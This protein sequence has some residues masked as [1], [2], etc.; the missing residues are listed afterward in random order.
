MSTPEET[1]FTFSIESYISGLMRSPEETRVNVSRGRIMKLRHV[2]LGLTASL[3][4]A[5]NL[6]AALGWSLT[7]AQRRAYLYYYAPLLMHSAD[8]SATSQWGFDWL[9]NFDFD[10]DGI[11]KNNKA[12]WEQVD[13]LVANPTAAAYASWR[14]RPTM[15]T[16]A[17]EYMEGTS[18]SLTMLYHVYHAK[19]EGSIHDWERIEIRVDNV[20]GTP[21]MSETIRYVTITQHETHLSQLYG[22][23]DL[24]FMNTTGG[25]HAMIWQDDMQ[26]DLTG[27]H[28]NQLN[29]IEN[30][31]SQID[32]WNK[33][34][35]VNAEVDVTQTSGQQDVH[36]IFVPKGDAAAVTYW[37][38]QVLTQNT[39]SQLAAKASSRYDRWSKIK[40]IQYE[41]QDLADIMPTHADCASCGG[42][43]CV[44]ENGWGTYSNHWG[45]E[46]IDIKLSERINS[47][48]G[49]QLV[50]ASSSCGGT[51]V[52]FHR[53]SLDIEDPSDGAQGYPHKHWF[54]GAYL[55]NG[56]GESGPA[57]DGT[58]FY[59][60]VTG[61]PK[62]RQCTGGL[63]Q[64]W[65]Q[66]DYFAHSGP[67]GS[68]SNGKWY[69]HGKWLAPGW[70]LAT[71]GGFDG[72]WTQLFDDNH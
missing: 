1:R 31:W 62:V 61:A 11:F 23:R 58:P 64:F 71:N 46:T 49:V 10:R 50:P 45:S 52:T 41:L 53:N 5:G 57:F 14:L 56:E 51:A 39:A 24:N 72:R 16:A 30:N 34:P 60:P 66:H 3:W 12:N 36:Y 59:D 22:H 27:F 17:I 68:T 70:N 29:F 32:S 4:T 2:L 35:S 8:E 43:A 69:E 28:K 18:K 26:G 19:E 25:R 67:V 47:E 6:S 20:T 65:C 9:T 13:S 7:D 21:S 42:V 44:T 38:A 40:R 48:T 54:W 55:Q 33:Q 37:N 63:G 15:Y